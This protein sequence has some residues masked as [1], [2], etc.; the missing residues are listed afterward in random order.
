MAAG[1]KSHLREA[2]K[3]FGPVRPYIVGKSYLLCPERVPFDFERA[4]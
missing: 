3:D 4:S 2:S 1:A